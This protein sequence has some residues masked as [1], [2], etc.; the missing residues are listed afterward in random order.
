[1][2]SGRR[3]NRREVLRFGGA[4]VA[5]AAAKRRT[6]ARGAA[7]LP[8]GERITVGV[9][10]VGGRG[11]SHLEALRVRGD[12][13][14]LAVA[15]VD[16]GRREAAAARVAGGCASYNDYRELLI[17]PDIDA[18]VIA[19]PDH[20]HALNAIDACEAGKDVYCEKPLSLTIREGRAMVKAARRTA[21]V[22][23]VGSQQRSDRRFRRACELVLSGRIGKLERIVT[24]I[25]EGPV[26]RWSPRM[27]PPPGLDWN[28]FVGPAPWADYTPNRC[29]DSFR[30]FYDYAGG[31]VTDWGAHHNDI[32][33][34]GN[35]T[36]F[37]GPV[38]VEPIS[39]EFPAKGPYE[40]AMRFETRAT[41]ANGVVLTTTS[42]GNDVEF[43][44][45]DGWVKVNR[46]RLETSR[47]EMAK[48]PPGMGDVRLYE[49]PGHLTDW[50]QCIR[51]RSRPLCDVEIGHRSVTACHLANIALR[52][53]RAVQWDP[54]REEIINDPGLSRWLSRPYRAPWRLG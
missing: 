20:W 24:R 9:I 51:I 28:F 49:S 22:F 39:V 13:A 8:A 45:T 34:W 3:W 54:E 31:M 38:K 52:N 25:G 17:R 41:Y 16:R 7:T 5:A 30:W 23:Q 11:S 10:G 21:A 36:S 14:V 40:T 42:T 29:F 18:V 19:T 27:D 44:G 46:D 1:M 50:I 43:H 48:D 26:G 12:V 4:V 2:G 32:A 47:P 6:E 15:D 37:T 35:G 33:Q 53:G